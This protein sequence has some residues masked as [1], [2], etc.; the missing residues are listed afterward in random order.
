MMANG[1]AEMRDQ[2]ASLENHLGDVDQHVGALDQ[3]VVSVEKGLRGSATKSTNSTPKSTSTGKKPRTTPTRCAASWAACLAHSP[4]T[5][6]AST[7]WRERVYR[8]GC[9]PAHSFIDSP[10]DGLATIG[11]IGRVLSSS[12]CGSRRRFGSVIVSD[13]VNSNCPEN[14]HEWDSM[15]SAAR[16]Q[17][18][19]FLAPRVHFSRIRRMTRRF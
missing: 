7:R 8:S 17:G 13:V 18:A 9:E 3:R 15:S 5:R 12:Q 6:N 10:S 4:T 16:R 2:F 14:S 1:F 11:S 19:F